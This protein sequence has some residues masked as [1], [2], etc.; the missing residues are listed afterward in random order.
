MILE[1]RDNYREI[2]GKQMEV[3]DSIDRLNKAIQEWR[4]TVL[5]Q[6]D[7]LCD[8]VNLQMKAKSLLEAIDRYQKTRFPSF[9]EGERG[10][11]HG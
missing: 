5:Y 3:K 2:I 1:L 11:R 8:L 7:N 4:K 9:I 6:R 10:V